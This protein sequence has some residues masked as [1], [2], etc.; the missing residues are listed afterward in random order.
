MIRD[1]GEIILSAGA[2]GSPQLLLL[3]GV[4]PESY[5]SSQ[6]IVPIHH[7]P[8]VG[9]YVYD[10]PRHGVAIM[11]PFPLEKT[12]INLVGNP[13]DDF[14]IEP[15]S[16]SIPFFNALRSG[17]FHDATAPAHFDVGY[18]LEKLS[19]PASY[20]KLKLASSTD[21]KVTPTVRFNYFKDPVD[22]AICVKAMRKIGEMLTT[23]SMDRFKFPDLNGERSFR[24]YGPPLPEDQ[25][26]DAA[27]EK[28][29]KDTVTTIWHYF[30][31]CAVGKVVDGD[32]RVKGINSLRVVDGSI[33]QLSPGT[34]PHAT[35]MM[36]GR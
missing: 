33:L 31:G 7:L 23:P 12:L 14:Y 26:N 6:Q 10:I 32:L 35:L 2:I 36:T 25:S 21:V 24:F 1:K 20:G 4:G 18:I 8:Y 28:F 27:M 13:S 19:T 22:L 34:N 5:L 11:S 17:L 15:L 3:S 16:Y 29:C 9:E 30:G